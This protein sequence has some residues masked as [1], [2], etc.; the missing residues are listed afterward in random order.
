MTNQT[1]ALLKGMGAGMV[2]GTAAAVLSC[3]MTDKDTRKCMKKRAD[4]MMKN[5]NEMIDTIQTML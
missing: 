5:M 1:N 2:I 4:K 3:K